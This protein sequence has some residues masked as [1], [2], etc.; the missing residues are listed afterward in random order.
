MAIG[1]LFGTGSES[2]SLYG[3]SLTSN[4][5]SS[6]IYFEWFIFKVSTGQP[7][8]PTGGSWD[9]LTNTGV[10][11]T[12]WSSTV[13]GVPLDNLWFSVAF[14]DSRNPTNI[15]WSTTTLLTA[16]TSVYATA[17]ADT[18]TGNGST[19]NWTLTQDP[20]VVNNLDVSING[21]TQTPV[22]DYTISG[23]TFTTTTAAPLGSIILVK[24]RQALPNSYYGSANNVQYTPA[25]TGA[26][27]TN[28]QAKLR[29]TVSVMDFGAVGDGVA[30]DTA[31]IQAAV[32]AAKLVNF[33]AGVYKVT[34]SINLPNGTWLQGVGG[35]QNT[36]TDRISKINFTGTSGWAFQ[37]VS[38]ANLTN[39]YGD[40]SVKGLMI[41]ASS[42]A[43][44]NTGGCLLFGNSDTANFGTY[45]F[46][47]RVN[48]DQ[49]WLTGNTNGI[50][51][52]FVKVFDS[53]ITNSYVAG[54]N[55]GTWLFGSDINKISQ[56][57]Y[58]ANKTQIRATT[59]GTFGGGLKIE[60]NDILAA[61]YVNLWLE[62]VFGVEI[63]DNYI[64]VV[65]PTANAVVQTGTLTISP[66]TNAVT[67]AGTAF[68]TAFAGL[69]DT[70]RVLIKVGYEY[71]Q[72]IG[73][74]TNT[75]MLVD[76][77]FFSELSGQAWS[78]VYGTG[79]VSSSNATFSSLNNRIDITST[80]AVVPRYY[81]L[82]GAGNISDFSG[83]NADNGQTV[84][85]DSS[86]GANISVT[87]RY[88]FLGPITTS[89]YNAAFDFVAGSNDASQARNL[90][91]VP[92][93]T[94]RTTPQI[95]FDYRNWFQLTGTTPALIAAN[96][97]VNGTPSVSLYNGGSQDDV[98]TYLPAEY[99]GQR[100]RIRIRVKPVSVGS[101]I[102]VYAGATLGAKTTLLGSF[103]APTAGTWTSYDF[104][105]TNPATI[106]SGFSAIT[107]SKN[108]T[109]LYY[110]YV[111]IEALDTNSFIFGT[112]SPESVYTAPVGA[113]YRRTNG[114]ANTTLYVK[115]SGTGNTGW[116]AK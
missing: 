8:T 5:A 110:D 49:C 84:V 76:A 13:N 91:D 42:I 59:S 99:Y 94:F 50:G 17:Y 48:I 116:V 22:T 60:H 80:S 20:V 21:V 44:A 63:L 31:A 93:T 105:T 79:V 18:F 12:G 3:T 85:V 45:G 66:Y 87:D 32:N 89:T 96:A 33:P 67:G 4:T 74:S 112:G 41:N 24:Y 30:D 26:V 53:T 81:C 2:N 107:V 103:T 52:Y 92:R 16:T 29:Q 57:R 95:L 98:S 97:D 64:E 28:V 86:P 61:T 72:V 46:T 73:Y 9:F 43:T 40:F 75:A 56:N 68:A 113:M 102:S 37:F 15:V 55:Y 27:S 19:T 62:G 114:G 69:D 10:P 104:C 83:D 38:P 54:F 78:I 77:P 108:S 36:A 35:F 6:F 115:E 25:G 11:P 7:A 106:A 70:R 109:I 71:R 82:G 58:I 1:N 34:S 14:V 111:I 39:F 23:T 101:T 100:L 88:K 51:I 90:V 47:G 65:A